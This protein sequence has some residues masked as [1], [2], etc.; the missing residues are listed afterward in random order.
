VNPIISTGHKILANR[1][2]YSSYQYC[3]GGT[4]FRKKTI[5]KQINQNRPRGVLDLGCG[6][7]PTLNCIDERIGFSG[8]DISDEYLKLAARKRSKT[9]LILGDVSDIK[10]FEK[11]PSDHLDLI[12]AMGL[13]HHLDDEKLRILVGN[14]KSS[15]NEKSTLVS[16]D[17]TVTN[18]SSKVAKW[19][20][21]NDRGKHVRSPEEILAFFPESQF[22]VNYFSSVREFNIPLDIVKLEIRVK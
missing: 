19:F 21:L 14:L 10:I 11:V 12:L 8:V 16:I 9:N 13:F 3:V 18:S 17:P 15:M 22:K 2:A 4:Q 5:L 20:A 1:Y 7:G 6:P